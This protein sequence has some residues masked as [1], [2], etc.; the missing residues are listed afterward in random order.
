MMQRYFP[1][2]L[3]S[4]GSLFGADQPSYYYV[5]G[6]KVPLQSSGRFLAIKLKAEPGPFAA[7]FEHLSDSLALTMQTSQVGVAQPTA[8]VRESIQRNQKY[9]EKELPVFRQGSLDVVA[10]QEVIVRF[11]P[12]V[13]TAEAESILRSLGGRYTETAGVAGRYLLS[14]DSNDSAIDAA[15]KLVEG[16]DTRTKIRY[17]EP[18]FLVVFPASTMRTGIAP[19]MPAAPVPAPDPLFPQQWA[20]ENHGAA[21]TAGADIRIRKAWSVNPGSAAVTLAILDDGVDSH[22]ADFAGKIV[23]P[24][25]AVTH[26]PNADPEPWDGHGT[27]CAGIAAA[28]TRNGVGISGVAGGV[29]LMPVQVA[30]RDKKD[31]PWTATPS[32][33]ATGIRQA[34]Q[35]GAD[36]ISYS[37]VMTPSNDVEDAI[38]DALQNGRHGKGLVFVFP[39]GNVSSGVQ[40]PANLSLTKPVIAVSATNEW[41]E[42]KT[43]GSKD[44]EDWWGSN[45]GPEVTVSAPGVH[46]VTTDISGSGGYIAGDYVANFNGTS[47]ATPQVAGVAALVISQFPDLTAAQVR[48]RI[49]STADDL[50]PPGFDIQFGFGRVNACRALGGTDCDAASNTAVAQRE[51]SAPNGRSAPSK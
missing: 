51:S 50:G 22:H 44:G 29:K 34:T 32:D 41:D 36:V 20:L 12:E 18:N 35:Q 2:I 23:H 3:I 4:L 15:N 30:L 42:F 17:A 27:A 45:F 33:L 11:K 38:D 31:G 25:S 6:A 46:I 19:V 28:V 1:I 47:S 14:V 40:Y 7:A 9:I 5:N 37:W 43:P 48:D 16:N 26:Q 13:P 8:A 49:A 24:F 10:Q 39:A 21:G